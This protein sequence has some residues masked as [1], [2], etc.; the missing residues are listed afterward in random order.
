MGKHATHK[1]TPAVTHRQNTFIQRVA[2]NENDKS[3]KHEISLKLM[4]SE[5]RSHLNLITGSGF[6]Q[7]A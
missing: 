7:E 1:H 6:C 2:P 5:S 4:Q 3:I